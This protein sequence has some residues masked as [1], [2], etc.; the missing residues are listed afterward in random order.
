MPNIRLK[1]HLETH[2]RKQ[3]NCQIVLRETVRKL[4]D[5]LE[6]L[7]NSSKLN[8]RFQSEIS[9]SNG[10]YLAFSHKSKSKKIQA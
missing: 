8:K 10:I 2:K 7:L 6:R 9:I 4:I 3:I 5:K 1:K